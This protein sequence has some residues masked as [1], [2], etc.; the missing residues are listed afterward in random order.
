M[1]F[2]KDVATQQPNLSLE[3]RNLLSVAY[4]NIVGARRASF[5]IVTSILAKERE[6]DGESGHVPKIM[7]YKAKVRAPRNLHRTRPRGSLPS[8]ARHHRETR[9]VQVQASAPAPS[10]QGT[11]C[12]PAEPAVANGDATHAA[13]HSR[14]CEL[15]RARSPPLASPAWPDPDGLGGVGPFSL[16]LSLP[17]H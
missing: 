15:E 1:K 8:P 2:M 10:A 5:R 4:K 16:S 13:Q 14:A 3:Q 6:K 7:A 9:H 17:A 12:A 11:C